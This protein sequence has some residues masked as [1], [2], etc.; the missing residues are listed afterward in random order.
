M[1]DHL[2]PGEWLPG[3]YPRRHQQVLAIGETVSE[4]IDRPQSDVQ[5]IDLA[6][7]IAAAR[8][9]AKVLGLCLLIGLVLGIWYLALAP[10]H[11]LAVTQILIDSNLQ[12]IVNTVDSPPSAAASESEILNQVEVMRSRRLAEVVAE[13]QRLGMDL[14]FI[15]PPPSFIQSNLRMVQAV[16]GAIVPWLRPGV[17]A[18]PRLMSSEAAAGLLRRSIF[19]ERIGRSSVISLGV[20]WSDPELAHRIATAYADAFVQDSLNA[21]LEASRQAADW[22]QQRLVELGESQREATQAVIAYRRE[23]GLSQIQEEGVAGRRLEALTNQLVIAQSE[24]AQTRAKAAQLQTIIDAGPANAGDSASLLS[25]AG[26]DE[27]EVA[28]IRTRYATIKRRLAEVTE[29]FGADHAQAVSLEAELQSMSRQVFVQLEALLEFY[30]NESAVADRREVELRDQVNAEASAITDADQT[31]VELTELQQRSDALRILYDSF[32]SRYEELVQ[33]Q[34]FPIPTA[35]ILTAPEVPRGAVSPSPLLILAQSLF[36]GLVLGI[37]LAFLNEKRERAFRIGQ[38]VVDEL[39]LRFIGYLP[40]LSRRRTKEEGGTSAVALHSLVR[41]QITERRVNAPTTTF[42]E[43]LR[44]TKLAIDALPPSD[45]CRVIGVVSAL[46]GEGKTTVAVALAEMLAAGGAKALL[47]DA[48][49]RRAAASALLAPDAKKGILDLASGALWHDVAVHDEDTG[50]TVLPAV[51][52]A[53][54]LKAR[55]FVSSAGL[56]SLVDALRNQFDYVVVDLPPFGPVVDALAVMPL[57][58]AFILVT[59]WGR[60]PRRLVRSLLENEP[61]LAHHIAGVVLNNVDIS[62]LPRFSQTDASERF[63]GVYDRFYHKPTETMQ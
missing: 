50:V 39:G 48:D 13:N 49:L 46:P 20:S 4:A 42:V 61:M 40:L 10:R 30:R 26:V 28:E 44:A 53:D 19:V 16:V 8:R 47:L 31:Q 17:D 5:F 14:A 6:R 12:E 29:E 18:A 15:D 41:R 60:T 25:G 56:R 51:V 11:Y 7:I 3:R 36:G 35:R 63:I 58:D 24:A 55:D 52:G 59:D 27:S 43:T 34:S 37:G 33:R 1:Q 62:A 21:N 2:P 22:L 9:Q 54:S 38:Q 45:G 23:T 57:T 32:L